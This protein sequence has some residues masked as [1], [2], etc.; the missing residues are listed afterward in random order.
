VEGDAARAAVPG[1]RGGLELASRT[2][3][4]DRRSVR[5]SWR[6]WLLAGTMLSVGC[7]GEGRRASPASA[8]PAGVVLILIDALRADHV[9]A[10]GSPLG[11]TPN[12]D[13][14]AARGVVFENA[15]APSSWTRST[16]ASLMTSRHPS[17]IG[18]LG[19]FDAIAPATITLPEILRSRGGFET[20][21]IYTNGNSGPRFGFAQGF[22][23]METPDLY[24][25]YPD[26]FMIYTAEGVTRKALRFIDERSAGRP[27]FLLL[28]Y[29]D[30][31]DPYLAHP[32]L[33]P[34]PEPPGRFDGSRSS[35]TMLDRTPSAELT[36]A[37]YGRIKHLYAGEVGYCD[38]W[39]GELL[40]GLEERGL[41]DGV[42]LAITSDHGEELWDRGARAHGRSL[43]QEMI[44]V[45]LLLDFPSS[46][47][48][49]APRVDQPVSLLD[50]A[51]T[52]TAA[53]GI[54]QPK[55]FQGTDLRPLAAGASQSRRAEYVYS[56][57][58]I[59]GLSFEAVRHGDLK[60]IRDRT[61][62][63]GIES[64]ELYDLDRDP[65]ERINLVRRR[66]SEAARLEKAL[67]GIHRELLAEA[68]PALRVELGGLDPDVIE[69]L[70]AL[71]YLGA[72]GAATP[73]GTV[74]E[75]IVDFSRSDHAEWQLVR[76]FYPAQQGRRWMAGVGSVLLGR[77]DGET[78]WRLDG[79][80]DLQ[81]HGGEALTITGRA[82]AGEPWRT[83]IES[84]GFF[85]LEGDLPPGAA[86]TV[87]L[88][89]ECD[90]EFIPAAQGGHDQRRLC[91]I[92][93]SVRVL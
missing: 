46:F 13:A 62:P 49:L 38:F 21:W 22:D 58:E 5:P 25:G 88:D 27:F 20:L 35:L 70:R 91:A 74:A 16:M 6:V 11:L 60:L 3:E 32:G 76:G 54:P 8:E 42:L 26:G 92:V 1:V 45:P 69:N 29:V 30:P 44:H 80:V 14:V 75:A 71:G 17:S 23:R 68:A 51:P 93:T 61:R 18:V 56:E 28:H 36:E 33:L 79:W 37:D 43:Y 66:P 2:R 40:R 90:H 89:F 83:I 85:T 73:V 82:N 31:H 64:L 67:D 15:V 4:A 39:I 63:R 50:V 34:T 9:G 7:A 81:W 78:A 59:D 48:G 65:G 55:E 19:R 77:N 12:L 10:H 53:F 57:M 84:S 24:G 52:I 86:S 41:R 72:G 87:R 47:G